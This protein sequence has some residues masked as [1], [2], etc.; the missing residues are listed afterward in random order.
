MIANKRKLEEL[1]EKKEKYQL[2]K[3]ITI[4]SSILF[5]DKTWDSFI[6]DPSDQICVRFNGTH[7]LYIPERFQHQILSITTHDPDD[8]RTIDIKGGTRYPNLYSLHIDGGLVLPRHE[9]VLVPSVFSQLYSAYK[10]VGEKSSSDYTAKELQS[11]LLEFF[12]FSMP[13]A[14]QRLIVEYTPTLIP[15][16]DIGRLTYPNIKNLYMHM[17][18]NLGW[19]TGIQ[20]LGTMSHLD[21]EL[22]LWIHDNQN[23]FWSQEVALMQQFCRFPHVK[24]LRIRVWIHTSGSHATSGD[25]LEDIQSI[26]Q[27]MKRLFQ[28]LFG[29]YDQMWHELKRIEFDICSEWHSASLPMKQLWTFFPFDEWLLVLKRSPQLS[30][31]GYWERDHQSQWQTTIE[32]ETY[33]N[34]GMFLYALILKRHYCSALYEYLSKPQ[35]IELFKQAALEYNFH[36]KEETFNHMIEPCCEQ[37]VSQLTKMKYGICGI[38]Y[39]GEFINVV[40]EHIK[41]HSSSSQNLINTEQQDLQYL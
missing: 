22:S 6:I 34:I 3:I 38:T 25:R 8:G 16:Q 30:N 18:Q 31:I 5:T 13:S 9:E 15:Y 20:T 32:E 7:E 4:S 26:W 41:I 17:Y 37:S 29:H 24:L 2:N 14:I 12:Y 23:L 35:M 1:D 19:H 28:G 27:F 10:P 11:V 36:V 21:G 40:E 39:P 33:N